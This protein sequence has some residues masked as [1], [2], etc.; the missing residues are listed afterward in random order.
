M[1]RLNGFN[2]VGWIF[3]F[4]LFNADLGATRAELI[5]KFIGFIVNKV[6]S[7]INGFVFKLVGDAGD[8]FVAQLVYVV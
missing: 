3:R 8:Y 5:G 2:T 7:G 4:N 1:E 6:F